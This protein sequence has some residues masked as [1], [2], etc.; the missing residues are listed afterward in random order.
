MSYRAF[1]EGQLSFINDRTNY[2][3]THMGTFIDCD[4]ET[5]PDGLEFGAQV[6]THLHLMNEL[7]RKLMEEKLQFDQEIQDI[8]M[9]INTHFKG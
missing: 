1:T 5:N 8:L 4:P 3:I 7:V 6:S 2:L 9:S